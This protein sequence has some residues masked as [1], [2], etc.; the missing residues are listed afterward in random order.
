MTNFDVSS[1]VGLNLS[2]IDGFGQTSK[3]GTH[4]KLSG[5]P[6]QPLVLLV[7]GVGGFSFVFEPL[8][9][10]LNAAGFRT[11]RYDLIGRGWSSPGNYYTIDEHVKQL[12]TLLKEINLEN[13]PCYVIAHSMGGIIATAFT[14]AHF[15]QVRG[16]CLL[17]PAGAIDPPIPGFGCLQCVVTSCSC[18][19]IPCLA[20]C[21]FS[22]PPP[23]NE[24][25]ACPKDHDGDASELSEEALN[26]GDVLMPWA[27]AWVAASVRRNS[28]TSLAASIA[29]APF[30]SFVSREVD[31]YLKQVDKSELKQQQVPMVILFGK[32]DPT[33]RNIR[34]QE[35][36][37]LFGDH[38]SAEACPGRHCFFVQNPEVVQPKILAFLAQCASKVPD[39]SPIQRN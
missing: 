25:Y 29:R 17:S 24:D 20:H 21:V 4:Y 23:L 18:C 39:T 14:V 36:Q 12:E 6:S 9:A 19:C 30:S 35:Y 13:E 28:A 2:K 5:E 7:H 37:A 15:K 38:V 34:V 31:V 3:S 27:E 11:L 26:R 33:C 32:H 22:G 8:E 16:C 1:I 10:A